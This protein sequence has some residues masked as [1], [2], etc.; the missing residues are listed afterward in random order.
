MSGRRSRYRTLIRLAALIGAAALAAGTMPAKTHA[1]ES[2]Y[3]HVYAF[4]DSYSDNG[5]LLPLTQ[6]AVAAKIPEAAVL[7]AV[8][9]TGTYWQGRWSNGPTAIED[10]A[11]QLGLGITDYAMG[12][13]KSGDGN[14]Y[15]WL[16]YIRDTG[17]RGQ[18][19]TF[20]ES[21]NG[22]PADARA[23]YFVAASA[24]DYFQMGDFSRTETPRLLAT[25]AAENTRYAV[26]QLV[27]AGARNIMVSKSYLLSAVPAVAA[28][29]KATAAAKTFEAQYDQALRDALTRIASRPGIRLTWFEW[30]KAT[31]DIAANA[32]R[33]GIANITAPCQVTMPKPAAA[34]GDPDAHLWWDEYHPSRRTHSLLAGTMLR[35][36]KLR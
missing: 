34:C 3:S 32:K 28:D 15:A 12:G 24:N 27:A 22:K 29:A 4:G 25:R 11:K 30:G 20:V 6:R 7:P 18:V 2:A 16:D 23:L 35:A 31:Q 33:N 19:R 36:L 21:L 10:V 14:Y 17:L 9:E 1:A 8:P 13:A 26:E 5:A